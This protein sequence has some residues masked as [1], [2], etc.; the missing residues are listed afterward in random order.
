MPDPTAASAP[1]I[2]ARNLT[3]RFASLTAVDGIDFDVARG[4][5]FGFLGPNGAGKTSA[6]RMIGCVSPVS[7]GT[8]T[9]LG[10]GP[11][12]PRTRD[13]RAAG[14]GAPAGH[15]GHGAVGPGQPRDLRS[16]L[17]ADPGG[18]AGSR[19]RPPRLR[20]A[21]RASER[22][23]RAPLGRH[24][25]P[26]DHRS[27]PDQRAV[28]PAARRAHHGPG[29]TGQAPA[30]GAPLPAQAARRDARPHHPLHGR[31]RAAV[32]PAGGDGQAGGSPRRDRRAS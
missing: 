25:A 31:G 22:Q 32:R 1:L 5:S 12:H 16:V 3:K 24:E 18:V 7:D 11:G 27:G 6:M 28:H 21:G 23:G 20:A 2:H 4:E 17:R 10:P 13:P 14:R 8:L 9:I 19:G 26:A 15:P 30:L 29:S